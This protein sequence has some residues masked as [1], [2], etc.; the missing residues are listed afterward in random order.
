[1]PEVKKRW[2]PGERVQVSWRE[3]KRKGRAKGK[4]AFSLLAVKGIA[5]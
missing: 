3:K 1:M 5:E 2:D 4:D